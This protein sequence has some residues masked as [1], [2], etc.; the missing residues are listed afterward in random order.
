MIDNNPHDADTTNS[1][2]FPRTPEAHQ[3]AV[4]TILDARWVPPGYQLLIRNHDLGLEVFANLD[5]PVAIAY[6]GKRRK[7][8]W[9]Y[10]FSSRERLEKRVSDYV[11]AQL[12]AARVR[13]ERK[14]KRVGFRHTLKVG[15]VL[16]CT[17]GY[18]QTNVDFYEVTRLV[19]HARVMVEARP[20]SQLSNETD[21]DRGFC[22]PLPGQYIGRA[23]RYR[24]AEG[25]RIKVES[26][27]YAR[28]AE[29]DEKD[30]ERTYKPVRWTSYA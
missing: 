8:D 26:F 24:V 2:A 25:N 4:S 14:Q 12:E 22:V 23:K 6:A 20:I 3:R 1:A 29:Y 9:H 13:R 11:D 7:C 21:T 16:V 10:T 30:G 15:D 5:R 18:E 28:P 17:W 27:A 19:G